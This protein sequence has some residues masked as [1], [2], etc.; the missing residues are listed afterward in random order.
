M[1]TGDSALATY[2]R[3]TELAALYT[4]FL[5][6]ARRFA[7]HADLAPTPAA[8]ELLH[9]LAK[10]DAA[11]AGQLK[12]VLSEVGIWV[13]AG[14]AAL[15]APHGLSHWERV[16]NDLEAHREARKQI[17]ELA[18]HF[19]ETEPALAAV[20]NRLVHDEDSHLGHL[21]ALIAR[22]DPQAFN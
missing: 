13:Q 18:V 9:R 20:L 3:E 2:E 8:G 14:P 5:A 22:A 10:E 1:A 6:R 15:P 16:V 11:C 4:G 12:D 21:R 7:V 17:L 19:A